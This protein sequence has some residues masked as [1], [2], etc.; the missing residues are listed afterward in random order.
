[1]LARGQQALSPE[2]FEAAANETGALVLDTRD[3]QV[4]A[5]GFIPNSVNIGINGNFA[6]W[7]GTL[8]PDIQQE[9]LL[10]TDNG[11]EEEVI[12]RLARVGYDHTIG[13]LQGGF[14]AWAKAGKEIDSIASISAN[15][16]ATLANKQEVEILDVRKKSEF[17]SE[18][19]LQAENAPL[20]DI[21]DSM[22]TIDKNKT[23]YVHCAG[24]YRSMI[25][26]SVLRARG[27]DN[28]I[29]VSGGFKA[30]KETGRFKISDY[31]CPSTLL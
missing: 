9:I 23:Y 16:L 10:V 25:F 18:H 7:A 14:E 4:F 20:D 27:Y 28:L 26:N 6:P 31:V 1:V 8:I 19:L 22:L 24:G 5:A 17:E 2:A 29:D 12:T 11:R 15:E 13:Y 21:N 30:I 3:A